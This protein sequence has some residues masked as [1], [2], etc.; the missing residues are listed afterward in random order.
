MQHRARVAGGG[1]V[2][3]RLLLWVAI[4]GAG[5]SSPATDPNLAVSSN[6]E[7]A[8]PVAVALGPISEVD[9]II[10]TPHSVT[11]EESGFVLIGGDAPSGCLVVGDSAPSPELEAAY[12]ISDRVERL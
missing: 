3:R 8:R 5:C 2:F 9:R 11:Y 6:I 4:L 12:L 10:P 7:S 1:L